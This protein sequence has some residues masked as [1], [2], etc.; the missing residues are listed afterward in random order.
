MVSPNS[1]VQASLF[2][3]DDEGLR[4][5]V[6]FN[7]TRVIETSPLGITV[8]GVDL[9]SGVSLDPPEMSHIDET[10]ATRGHHSQARN[11][12]RVWNIP[13]THQQSGRK[14]SIEFRVYD[15]GVAFRYIVPGT[16]IQHVDGE[17]SGW[18]LMPN[19]KAW[20]FERL[21]KK[22]KL[23]SYAG[24]WISTDVSELETVSPPGP[25]QGTPIVFELPNDLGYA[26]VTKAATYNYS[27]MRLKAV[28]NR[29]LVA[30][31]T[32][33]ADGFDV[34]GTIVTP[35]RV[36]ML[37][38]DLN[39]L[40]N[41]DL[42]KNLNP[43]PDRELFADTSYIKPGRTV[44]SW[45]TLGLGDAATQKTFIDLAAEMGFEYSTI[46]DGWKDWD[47]PWQTIKSLCDHAK[48]KRVGVWLWVHSDDIRDPANSYAQ[49]QD[50]FEQVAKTGPVGLKI[51]FM[52]GESKELVDFE[53]AALR[54]AAQQRLM[55]N[56]HGCHASTG[57]ERTYPNEMTREGIRG[58]EVNKMAEGP[59]T[60]SHN[61][62][63][64]FTRFVVGH[65][66]YTPVLF[67]NP[68]PTTW[69]HQLATLVT[70]TTGLQTYAEHPDTLMNGPILKNAFS[71]LQAIPPVWDDTIVLDGSRIGKLA[72]MARRSGDEWFVG[73]LNGE[74][75]PR[76]HSIDLGFL[77]EGNYDVQIARDDLD[78]PRVNLV[79]LNPKAKLKG[80]T[81]A[82]PFKVE[83]QMVRRN[84]SLT[85][86]LAPG[87]GYVAWLT[88]SGENKKQVSATLDEG[89]NADKNDE[90][91]DN[92]KQ[93]NIVLFF[94]DDLGWYDL[95]YRNPKFET[96]NIDQLASESLDFQRAYIA[97][98]T[99]SP[100]RATLLT[101]KHPARL[102]M[103]RH[104]PND[105]KH[106]FD[107]F[108][109]TD[110]EFNFWEGDPAKFPCRNW[111]PLE[112]TSYAEALKEL[113][114]YNQFFGKWHL[115]HEA[116]HPVM[117]GFDEQVGTT[118]AG[119]PKS[120]NPPFFKNSDVFAGVQDRYLT[121]ALTDQSVRF[122][123]QYDR[124]QPFM[125]S[126]WYYNVHRP[127]VGRADLVKDLEEKGYSKVDAVYAAQVKAVDESVGRIRQAIREK[128]IGENTIVIFLSDQGSWYQNLPL[129]GSKRVDTLCEGGA[130]VP[131]M[132]HWPGVTKPKSK[133]NSLVQSTDL[134]PT[135]VE[136]AGGDR[137]KHPDLDGVSL[138][139]V[140]RENS[141]LDR[142]E[143]LFGYRAYEDLYASVRE[144]DWKLLAY[145]SG[146]VNLY[147]I[148]EDER[149]QNDLAQTQ[150][151]IVKQLTEKLIKWEQR[152]NVQQYSGVK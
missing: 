107:E 67:A 100:S 116:Y 34:D 57:E 36:T 26:A 71:M 25:V 103:V 130:R 135:L 54:M 120:Y 84:E 61:A 97:S 150:P 62:A 88:K 49:M 37:A 13:V 43:A 11:H 10:Y 18:K 53:I 44:W 144:G 148:A 99:C 90:H 98:P 106:G 123:E 146:K 86:N 17:A 23:K 149:E 31:F 104:I 33:G 96:P 72:A 56:F 151:A 27:G 129:R 143:P 121:D 47:T 126:M 68:G 22:W 75:S 113:G 3:S 8:D 1:K 94:V 109:R 141:T 50:Y 76:Q 64:P 133:N 19:S 51:D 89:A 70:F 74:Q 46:D 4:Y 91:A 30:D 85:M 21:T 83:H 95:G 137:S 45:E 108:G 132:I 125:L 38:D 105:T 136:I 12:C 15:D 28:G 128:G 82:I 29:R 92:G 55:I 87:G 6:D 39:K 147:N 127:P 122:I 2:R 112:H 69:T 14:Y 7:G 40:V 145:R 111:L 119:H 142:G 101:G 79:G 152:M 65:A 20:F 102:Q 58:I 59:L 16:G 134:F 80:F 9:G 63:L 24:E 115:G 66:D 5:T 77:G 118:N 140:I 110:K 117:Q 114:Y 131:L 35:W 81:T 139:S 73:I 41:S 60:A 42:I 48:E 78:A 32:E 124:A 93:P 52:N 138:V